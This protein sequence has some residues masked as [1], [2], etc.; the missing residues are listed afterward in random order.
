MAE[1]SEAGQMRLLCYDDGPQPVSTR[2]D[3]QGH[4]LDRTAPEIVL[5]RTAPEVV[6]NEYSDEYRVS[7]TIYE[8]SEKEVANN[9]LEHTVKAIN[10]QSTI[11]RHR[12]WRMVF[13]GIGVVFAAIAIAV[14]IAI[15]QTQKTKKEQRYKSRIAYSIY[16]G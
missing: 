6:P 16:L 10:N 9:P 3:L 13:L 4:F 12:K 15:S 1:G 8:P 2:N 14:G 7:R 11:P 5:D